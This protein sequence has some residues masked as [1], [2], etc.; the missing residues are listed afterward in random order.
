MSDAAKGWF[1]DWSARTLLLLKGKDGQDFLQR[2]STNDVSNLKKGPIRTI[3]TNEKGRIVDVLA[4]AALSADEILVAGLSRDPEGTRSWLER[5]IIMEDLR[6]ESSKEYR[7]ILV[8]KT[9]QG[10]NPGDAIAFSDDWGSHLLMP[11]DKAGAWVQSCGLEQWADPEVDRWRTVNGIPEWKS[12]I[13]TE[14]NPLEAGLGELI[15]W[16]KGC[17][18]GQE[19]I[20]RLDTYNKI[21]RLRVSLLLDG[22]C[23]VSSK[24]YTDGNEAGILTS[25]ARGV[26]GGF[27]G[28]G[29]VKTLVAHGASQLAVKGP[30]GEIGARIREH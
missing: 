8:G 14:Y 25:V 4:A 17:Y 9:V 27:Y 16:T 10:M 29:Y 13:S 3:L 21:Q 26:D 22:D 11:T 1:A 2:L 24:L 30:A 5:Y 15:S 18:I 6:I 7:H 19:V 28:I 12:E 20:A 23:P